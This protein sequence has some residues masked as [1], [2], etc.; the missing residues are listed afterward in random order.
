[1][2]KKHVEETELEKRLRAEAEAEAVEQPSPETGE[3]PAEEP[4]KDVAAVEAERDEVKDRFVR[5]MAE[6]DN[7]RKRTARDHERIRKTAAESLMRD[8]LPVVDNLERALDHAGDNSGGFIDGVGMV[9]R[10]FR[11]ALSKHGLEIIAAAGQPFDPSV[12]EAVSMMPS[13]E[14]PPDHVLQEFQKGYRLGDFVLRPAKV[15]VSMAPVA[16]Q[17]DVEMA[18]EATCEDIED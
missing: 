15:V 8:L 11:E 3:A 10:Q 14:I 7:Y 4:K 12:H 5:L 9:L 17:T 6:F 18:T 2:K 1:M 16:A 13:E